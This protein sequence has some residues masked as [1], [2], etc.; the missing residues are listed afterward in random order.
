MG[1]RTVAV[2]ALALAVPV[3]ILAWSE[4]ARAGS[5]SITTTQRPSYADGT[6]TVSVTIRNSGDEAAHSVAPVLRFRDQTT[7]GTRR[8]ELAP[9][10]SV[11][12][13]LALEV[14][15]LG[16]GRWIFAIAVDYADANQYPFQALQMGSIAVGDVGPAKVTATKV[17]AEPIAKDGKLSITLKN[18]AGE[19]RAV[20]VTTHVPEGLEVVADVGDVLLEPW[21]ERVVT[22]DVVNRT[23]LAGSRYPVFVT[24]EYDAEDVHYGAVFQGIVEITS[25]ANAVERYG[26]SLW[27]Y[28]L[29]LG[30]VFLLL[31][32]VRLLRR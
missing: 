1:T 25:A 32:G 2:G 7:R 26:G 31:V 29:V 6:L 8:E 4:P 28:A 14:G 17:T 13:E 22:A 27:I 12:D 20:Q 24:V 15:T 9:G 3:A 19:D 5:I 30:L 10:Q 16:T 11:E 21:A 23:A 18:L